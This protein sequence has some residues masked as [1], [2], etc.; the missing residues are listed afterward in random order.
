MALHAYH[1]LIS[2]VL[3]QRLHRPSYHTE[4]LQDTTGLEGKCVFVTPTA[5]GKCF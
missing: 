1:V 3:G 2:Q 5:A 4:V